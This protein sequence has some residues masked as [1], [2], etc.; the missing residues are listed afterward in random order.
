MQSSYRMSARQVLLDE[1]F[2]NWSIPER[3]AWFNREVMVKHLPKELLPGDLI[4]GARFNI[5][6]SH[7]L[8]EKEAKAREKMIFGKDGSRSKMKCFHDHGYG[9]SGATSGHLVPGYETALKS[10]W[11]GI[12]HEIKI[13][14]DTFSDKEKRSDRGA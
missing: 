10:G 14:Y 8:T 4:A 2:W 9:N 6:T 11:K 1:N 3:R 5:M 13:F 12:N 7:C